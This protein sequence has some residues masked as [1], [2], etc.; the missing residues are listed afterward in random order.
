MLMALSFGMYMVI[1]HL[2]F[3]KTPIMPWPSWEWNFIWI[4]QTCLKE[5]L[6]LMDYMHAYICSVLKGGPHVHFL[7][8]MYREA[9]YYE[10]YF[11]LCSSAV[12]A[13]ICTLQCSARH[14][15]RLISTPENKQRIGPD[16]R[17][18]RSGTIQQAIS[19]KSAS[20]IIGS[21]KRK[22]GARSSLTFSIL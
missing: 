17:F 12:H 10:H 18:F 3:Y 21:E 20:G 1:Q 14:A 8:N 11:S 16:R 4:C 6:S 19:S 5:T 2:Q 7:G 15:L 22:N 13:T 9:K